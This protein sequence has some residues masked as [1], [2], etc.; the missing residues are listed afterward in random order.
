ME[1]QG[2]LWEP[3]GGLEK[4]GSGPGGLQGGAQNVKNMILG[5][6]S[7]YPKRSGAYKY[8]GFSVFRKKTFFFQIRFC[9]F[10]GGAREGPKTC[11]GRPRNFQGGPRESGTGPRGPFLGGPGSAKVCQGSIFDGKTGLVLRFPFFALND[12]WKAPRGS[13]ERAAE[14]QEFQRGAQGGAPSSLWGPEGGPKTKRDHWPRTVDRRAGRKRRSRALGQ[15]KCQRLTQTN[16]SKNK[17]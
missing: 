14:Q 11:V 5:P 2:A 13:R 3:R 15:N 9:R 10:S 6:L 12:F 1:L 16:M 7:F 17:N 4:K 8:S